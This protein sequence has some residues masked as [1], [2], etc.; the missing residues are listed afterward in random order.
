MQKVFLIICMVFLCFCALAQADPAACPVRDGDQ[1]SPDL[2]PKAFVRKLILR[3]PGF[4]LAAQQR[5]A[6]EIKSHTYWCDN[7]DE[8][9][10]RVR[11]AYQE[12]GY[13]KALIGS[14]MVRVIQGDTR[15]KLIDVTISVDKGQLYRL[16]DIS[17]TRITVFPE[18]E[19]RRQFPMS[20]GDIFNTGKIHI[21]L[22][23][24]R[25]LYGARGYI[26]FTP[27]P[28]TKIDDDA[29][30]VSLIIDVDEGPQFHYGKL[31]VDGEESKPGA[32]ATLLKAWQAYEGKPCNDDG[33]A[34]KDFLRDIHA[35]PSV[36]FGEV[37]RVFHDEKSALLNFQITLAKPPEGLLVHPIAARAQPS[38]IHH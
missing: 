29:N 21:G 23:N 18:A 8:I 15:R 17:F 32:R 37:F 26:D 30:L 11:Q 34:L 20:A 5:I 2:T 19:L 25:K 14:P 33:L 36:K 1:W 13:F 24:T 22:E 27:V 35:A 38:A 6:L 7:F 10:E 9:A 12:R 4:S 31:T 3:N 28:D 16:K